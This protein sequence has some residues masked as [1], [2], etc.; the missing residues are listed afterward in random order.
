MPVTA[1]APLPAAL[2]DPLAMPVPPPR[3]CRSRSGVPAVCALDG[4]AWIVKLQAVID[5][6]NADRASAAKL[7]AGAVLTGS[8]SGAAR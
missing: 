6:A 1:Y 7:S 3:N 2:T 5:R 4:L 8:D